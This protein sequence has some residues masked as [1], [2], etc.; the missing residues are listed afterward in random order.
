MKRW[1]TGLLLLVM[2][3]AF[4]CAAPAEER[5][6][7]QSQTDGAYTYKFKEAGASYDTETL[8]YSI[9]VC[10]IN[11]TKCY[12]TRIWMQEPGRQIRKATAKWRTSLSKAEDLAKKVKGAAIVIN[13][14]GYVTK[15]YPDIPESYPGTSED[16]YYT[17]LGSL[18]ITDGEIFRNLEGVP[19]YGLTLEADGLH[20]YRGEDNETVLSRNPTQT[21]SFFEGCPL[22]VNGESILNTE[23]DF[24]QRRAIRTIIAKLDDHNYLLLTATSSHGFSLI[25]AVDYLNGEFSPEWAYN[26][27]G[28][29]STA[30]FRRKQG[31]K[32]LKLIYGAGQKIVDVMGFVEL[33]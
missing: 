2:T 12:L 5:Q 30:L 31:K 8:K 14:S 21:W 10:L 3:A 6:T 24:A 33:D 11:G 18:T 13:G 17:P 20:M 29:P 27:D 23:W 16:Y 7:A 26:L 32:T 4:V 19:Y 9:E 1:I 28:G 15:V 22:I 25:E